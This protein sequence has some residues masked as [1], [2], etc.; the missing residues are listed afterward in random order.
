MIVHLDLDTFFVSA[1][2]I[3]DDS[4]LNRP[5]AVGGRSNLSIFDRKQKG[6][7][8]YNTNQGAFVNPVFYNNHKRDFEDFFIDRDKNGKKRVRGIVVTSSYEARMQ[9][10]KTGMP[11][12]QALKLS[13]NMIV[14]VPNYLLYHELSHKLH[15][16]LQREIPKVEQFS[17]DEFFGDLRGWVEER[18]AKSWADELKQKIYKEFKLPISIGLSPAK[19]IAKL[20]TKRAKPNGVFL[21]KKE[22]I[23]SFIE[24]IP[25]EEFP[26]IGRGYQRRLKSHYIETLGDLKRSKHILYRWKKPGIRLYHRVVGDDG[27]SVSQR[28]DRKSVGISRTFDPISDHTEVLRRIIIMARHISFIV[29][30]LEVLPTSYYLRLKYQNG[31]RYKATKRL[32][33]LFSEALCKEVFKEMF[34]SRVPKDGA[35]IKVSMS[36]YNFTYQTKRALSILEYESDRKRRAIDISILKLRSKYSLDIIKSGLEV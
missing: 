34:E 21:V 18:D 11:L 1:H 6:I 36:V 22:E 25:I 28:G 12:A 19:W 23:G 24:D 30:R 4:L 8:L 35:V 16:Y 27:E 3:Y 26:G 15:L 5:V 9:G 2:R 7:K 33:R 32:D 10:V 17:I 29:H 14:L 31:V 13:P 20:A